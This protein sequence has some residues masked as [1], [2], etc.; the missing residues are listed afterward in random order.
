MKVCY[1]VTGGFLL[2]FGRKD[3]H[4]TTE[5]HTGERP[6]MRPTCPFSTHSFFMVFYLIVDAVV[7]FCSAFL[8]VAV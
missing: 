4:C 3:T 5:Y 6:H 7:L 2:T 1:G 8:S